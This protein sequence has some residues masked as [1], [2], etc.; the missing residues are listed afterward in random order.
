MVR[1]S[2]LVRIAALV[3]AGYLFAST[4]SSAY[5][6]HERYLAQGQS[7]TYVATHWAHYDGW[8]YWC[9][10]AN[11]W[12]QA[13][14]IDRWEPAFP[15]GAVDWVANCSIPDVSFQYYYSGTICP[16]GPSGNAG[17][18]CTVF[19]WE[20]NTARNGRYIT[21]AVVWINEKD[22]NFTPGGLAAVANHEVGHIYGLDENFLDSGGQSGCNNNPPFVS[23]M[24]AASTSGGCDFDY[25]TVYDWM[26]AGSTFYGIRSAYDTR[27]VTAPGICV[28]WGWKDQNWSESS[29]QVN[30][31][32]WNGSQ[33]V[34]VRTDNH[35]A[36]VAAG[37]PTDVREVSRQFCRPSNLPQATYTSC[38]RTTNYVAGTNFW[39]CTPNAFLF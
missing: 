9:S 31:Y 35:F 36:N 12:F 37:R 24:D 32:Y 11:A 29:Y 1:I 20:Y 4:V 14:V 27:W 10:P 16:I 7:D 22:W 5:A 38:I 17:G 19:E 25:P 8:M 39:V 26:D 23:V 6:N 21:G 30:Y 13:E 28:T 34:F 3:V 2:S 15:G 18:G 33:W